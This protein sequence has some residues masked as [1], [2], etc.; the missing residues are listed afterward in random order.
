M[1]PNPRYMSQ[2]PHDD[3]ACAG[4]ALFEWHETSQL[5]H[6]Y[7]GRAGIVTYDRV[8]TS[9]I[10]QQVRLSAGFVTLAGLDRIH[11]GK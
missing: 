7:E 4:I 6:Y 1:T 10:P 5:P 2:F 3:G 9:R 11:I 8:L